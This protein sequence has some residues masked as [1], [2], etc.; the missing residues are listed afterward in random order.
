[1]NKRQLKHEAL[2]EEQKEHV[3]QR[4][5][6]ICFTILTNGN[7][8]LRYDDYH[9]WWDGPRFNDPRKAPSGTALADFDDLEDIRVALYRGRHLRTNER[10]YWDAI[11]DEVRK[12]AH[13]YSQEMPHDPAVDL[14]IA[15]TRGEQLKRITARNYMWDRLHYYKNDYEETKGNK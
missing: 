14:D 4:A 3:K 2:T 13:N 7:S 12:L 1:M 15:R 5:T 10:I 8:F 9:F 6:D 11:A